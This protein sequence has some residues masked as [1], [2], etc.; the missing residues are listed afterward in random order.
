METTNTNFNNFQIWAE[1]LL[2]TVILVADEINEADYNETDEN[3][4]RKHLFNTFPVQTN[5][6][7][8]GHQHPQGLKDIVMWIAL[9]AKR[10]SWRLFITHDYIYHS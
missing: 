3:L 5:E 4:Q 9:C 10:L 6:D 8:L 1:S 2:C 7:V